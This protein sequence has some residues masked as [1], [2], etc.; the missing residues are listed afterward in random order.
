MLYLIDSIYMT[1]R[2]SMG[3]GIRNGTKMMLAFGIK[4]FLQNIITII[5]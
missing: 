4:V 2:F 5:F 3:A 1:S